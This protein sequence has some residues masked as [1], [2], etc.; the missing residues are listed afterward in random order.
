MVLKNA[1]LAMYD[2]KNCNRKYYYKFYEEE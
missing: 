1:D 2:C